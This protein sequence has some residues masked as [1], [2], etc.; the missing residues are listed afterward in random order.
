MRLSVIFSSI[1]TFFQGGRKET[2][3]LPPEQTTAPWEAFKGDMDL[4]IKDVGWRAASFLEKE[5]RRAAPRRTG[6]GAKSIQAVKSGGTLLGE[7]YRFTAL[8]YM[9]FTVP[10]GTK[11]H[12]VAARRAKALRF[13][14]EKGPRGPGIY[15]FKRVQHPGYRPTRDWR[16]D[17]M[18]KASQKVSY[19]FG[20]GRKLFELD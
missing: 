4:H 1:V 19:M 5:L 14:W 3:K 7:T 8:G 18:R 20:A 15:F 2:A 13:F 6:A 16:E 12:P 10:P 9:L 17:A 11:E